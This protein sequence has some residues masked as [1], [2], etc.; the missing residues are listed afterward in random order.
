[1]C[2]W[3]VFYEGLHTNASRKSVLRHEYSVRTS[4]S[5]QKVLCS[6][7]KVPFVTDQ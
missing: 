5:G 4:H 6:A 1:M 2:S 3:L 7:S